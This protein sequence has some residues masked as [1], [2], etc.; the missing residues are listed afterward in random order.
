M[1]AALGGVPMW[2]LFHTAWAMSRHTLE[3]KEAA[4]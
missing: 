1:Q 3:M 4:N 2:N